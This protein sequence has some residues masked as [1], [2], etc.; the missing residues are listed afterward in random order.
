MNVFKGTFK[1]SAVAVKRMKDTDLSADALD[2]FSNDVGV[3]DTLRCDK[4]STS[5]GVSFP[6]TS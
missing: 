2:E 5:P 4:L 6:T 1:G 3:L